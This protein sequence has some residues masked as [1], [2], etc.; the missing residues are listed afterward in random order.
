MIRNVGIDLV[1]VIAAFF[2]PSVHFFMNT[3]YYSTPLQTSELLFLQTYLRWIFLICVPLFMIVTGYLMT[4]KQLSKKYYKGILSIIGVYLFY[5][6]LSVFIRKYYFDEDFSIVN[7]IYRI[8]SFE[9]NNYSWYVNMYIG[10]FLLIPF[11]N[12]I[13]KNLKNQKERIIL[14]ATL[15]I[16]SGLPGFINSIPLVFHD[17]KIL[18]FPN[19]WI[20]IYPLAYYFIGSYIREYQPKVKKWLATLLFGLVILIETGLTYYFAKGGPFVAAAGYYNSITVML[21]SV[22]FFMIFYDVKI[23]NSRVSKIISSIGALTLDIYLSSYLVDRIIYP[24]V[25]KEFELQSSLTFYFVPI[26]GAIILI[27]LIISFTRKL[28]TKLVVNLIN[29]LKTN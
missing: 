8:F 18:Y 21:S 17:S 28:I 11:L 19:W 4:N 5:S 3:Y 25:L 2:V 14:I 1:K 26:V 27:T 6:I 9:A 22:F 15:V 29:R 20:N 23:K 10:L 13:F 12:I 16:L 7:W 24:Y